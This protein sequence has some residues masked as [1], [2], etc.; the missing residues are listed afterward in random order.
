MGGAWMNRCLAVIAFLLISG[1]VVFASEVVF[2]NAPREP[3]PT[4]RLTFHEE[5][6]FRF[7]NLNNFNFVHYGEFTKAE[8]AMGLQKVLGKP[9]DTIYLNRIRLGATFKVSDNVVL[10]LWGYD[11]RIWDFS[12][13]R[14]TFYDSKLG[15]RNTP[16]E[17]H[18]ELYKG[19]VEVRFPLKNSDIR[20][21]LGRQR[22][23]YGD[24]R[25]FGLCNWTNTGP[26]LWDAAKV[27]YNFSRGYVDLFAGRTKVNDPKKFSLNHRHQF[28]GIGMYSQFRLPKGFLNMV[29]E[30]FFAYKGD[31]TD[32]YAG[33]KGGT[34]TL[35][36]YYAGMRIW[37]R[38]YHNFDYDHLFLYSILYIS[39]FSSSNFYAIYFGLA[40]NNIVYAS[41]F[42]IHRY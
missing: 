38:D 27:S 14:D 31:N 9:D 33:E 34:G 13:P 5:V 23:D 32:K 25:T 35:N 8:K 39:Y 26:Y 7:E 19:Y 11:S 36:E 17:D 22:L 29:V 24:F 1:G 40:L 10:S 3:W 41:T 30:P 15:M 12:I 28:N 18:M 6:R 4:D 21:K 2:V 20:L 37:G 16:Y 42:C